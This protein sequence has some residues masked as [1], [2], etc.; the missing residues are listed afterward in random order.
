MSHSSS[1]ASLSP[2]MNDH[3]PHPIIPRRERTLSQCERALQSPS[4]EGIIDEFCR[5]KGHGYIRPKE[6][7]SQLIF[8]HV[9]DIDDDYVPKK[10][11]LVSFKKMLMPPKNEKI[12]AVHIK[13]LHLAEGV[14]HESWEEAVEHDME[15][16]R[17]SRVDSVTFANETAENGDKIHHVVPHISPVTHVD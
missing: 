2:R 3:L 16:R 14:K 10:G 17:P 4:Y 7:P 13:L 1:S 6:N 9:S 8:V 5:E 12:M 15:H 11:D